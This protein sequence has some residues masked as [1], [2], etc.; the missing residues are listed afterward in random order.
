ML[1]MNWKL[2]LLTFAVLPLIVYA[3]KVFRDKVRDSY[4]R[5]RTA[6]ARINSFLQEAVSRHA[7]AATL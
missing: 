3:T 7:G 2:A 6:I 4:R 1:D 5:I